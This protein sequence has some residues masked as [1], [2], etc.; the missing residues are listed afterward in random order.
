[1]KGQGLH[2]T[3]SSP[4]KEVF[5]GRVQSVSLPGTMKPFTVLSRHAPIV[6]TLKKG[7]IVY[8]LLDDS[9]SEQQ[10]EIEGGFVEMNNNVLSVCIF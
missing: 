8:V 7:T 6:S 2:L 4:E 9:G 3:I 10:V 1:M 5:N